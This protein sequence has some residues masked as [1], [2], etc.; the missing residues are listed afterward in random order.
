MRPP[1]AAGFVGLLRPYSPPW[2]GLIMDRK[3]RLG[4][5]EGEQAKGLMKLSVSKMAMSLGLAIVYFLSGKLGLSL[6][7][8]N[9]SATA[10]WP[11]A[12]IALAAVLL[13]GPR[14]WPGIFIGAFLAN[15]TTSG[16]IAS[17][18][19]IAAG[20]TIEAL[21]GAGLVERFAGGRRAFDR[22][23]TIFT[24]VVAAGLFSTALSATFGVT[25]LALGGFARS[26]QY[27]AVWLTWW[28]GDMVSDLIVAPLILLWAGSGVQRFKWRSF[29]ELFFVLL[30]VFIAGQIVF[31]GWF[32]F[33][34]KNYP[35]EYLTIPLL[36]WAALRLGRRGT[37]TAAAVMSGIATL[38]T[39]RGF[40]PFYTGDP[41][42]SLLL[43]QAFMGTMTVMALSLAALTSEQKKTAEELARSEER[44]AKA[45]RASPDVL[46]ISRLSDGMIIEVNDRWE[47]LFGYRREEALGQTPPTLDLYVDPVDRRKAVDIMQ[48]EGSLR[49]YPLD[50]KLRSGEIRQVHLSVE[51]I[52]VEGEPCMLSIIRDV[53]EQKRAEE[54][55]RESE[56]RLWLALEATG[57]GTWD[58]NPVTGGLK[59]SART[60]VMFGLPPEA[61]VTA[62]FFGELIHPEDRARVRE[63]VERALDPAGGGKYGIEFRTVPLQEGAPRWVAARGQAFF[64]AAGR[65]VRFIGTAL[66]I[67]DRKRR[68]EEL[69]EK[70]REA[71][72]ASRLKSQILS[73]VSHE[74]RT[75]LNGIIGY[76]HLLLGGTYGPV[77]EPQRFPM[78]GVLRNADELL[79]LIN[80]LLDF[81]RIESGKL[82][83][84]LEPIEL[85][86]LL[87]EVLDGLKPLVE[88][89]TLAIRFDPSQR[90]PAVESDRT[91]VRQVFSN[92]LSNAIKF[93]EEGEIRIL[94]RD[95][96]DRGGVEMA[97]HDTGIGIPAEELPKIFEAFHQVDGTLTREF[98]GTGLGLAIVKELVDLLKAEIRASSEYGK[99]S[100]FTLYLPY[101][102]GELK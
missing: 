67:T 26:D 84:D 17:S 61:E 5:D 86:P 34:V 39:L 85:G 36:L 8:L 83:L 37:V 1:E 58:F 10:V 28:L 25:S 18:F 100:T 76:T 50:V 59:W 13:L 40:G 31:G 3:D 15:V 48:K 73:N 95:R 38:G 71:Q 96:P 74:L 78:E 92:L 2:N 6:A 32:P 66:D 22:P 82:S 27:G 79:N 102:F 68:E 63:A 35:L 93:T 47:G 43:L 30:L 4:L 53:T 87:Q 69:K 90:L 20:N 77:D 62:S 70:T 89:K 72:E 91:R 64:D 88:K 52:V 9:A 98:G 57:L 19:G 29:V 12:G 33:R 65:P 75:P 81:S 42:E 24:Y 56:D 11:P 44:F 97:V 101:R 14:I 7:F 80:N 21:V 49:E 46:V 51:K 54:A 16:S 94:L 55:L 99:G 23:Q 45:F 60:K 41:N